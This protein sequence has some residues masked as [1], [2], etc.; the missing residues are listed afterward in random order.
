MSIRSWIAAQLT[1]PTKVLH[2]VGIFGIA[3]ELIRHLITQKP[4]DMN[5][6]YASFGAIAGGIVQD[7]VNTPPES[8]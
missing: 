5:A 2:A 8:K 6:V 7:R 4:V 1:D 3:S